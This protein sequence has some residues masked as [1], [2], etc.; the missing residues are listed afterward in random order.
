MIRELWQA[1]KSGR[2]GSGVGIAERRVE[3]DPAETEPTLRD[4]WEVAKRL[5]PE[6]RRQI[7]EFG[8]FLEERAQS[9]R[10][11]DETGPEANGLA[12]A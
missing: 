9:N 4:I 11:A 8:Q 6:Q 10:E 3:Y 7:L 1:F 5:T 2:L 12:G